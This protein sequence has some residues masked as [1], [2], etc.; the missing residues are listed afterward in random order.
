M[1]KILKPK[2]NVRYSI[3]FLTC[4]AI[5]INYMDRVNFSVATPT[6]MKV[7]NISAVQIGLMGSAFFIPYVLMMLP[8]GY[9]LNKIGP[10]KVL[11]GSLVFWGLATVATA[12]ASSVGTFLAT[13]IFMGLFEAP[14]FPSAS[15]VVAVWFPTEERT[16][17]SGLFDS[18]AR[19]G[20]AFTPP[21]V[22]AMI[23]TWGWQSSFVITG[24]I[25][26][27]FGFVW[28][29]LYHEPDDHPKVS[30]S[31]IAY[32]RKHEIINKEDKVVSKAIPMTRLFAYP[33]LVK[34]GLG[35]AMYLY[36]WNVFT[37]WMPA[38]FVVAKGFSLKS[39]GTAA[40]IPYFCAVVLEIIG[41]V[42]FDKWLRNGAH[43][44]SLR[45]TGMAISLI[46]SAVF[47]Y[48]TIHASTPFWIVF[49]LSA[50][51]GISGFGAGN[52]Q[53]VPQDLA[54][55]GQAGGVSGVYALFGNIGSFFA[56]M[57]T[58]FIIDTRFGYDGAFL[59]AA[60]VALMG[61]AFYIFNSYERIQPKGVDA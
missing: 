8:T 40:M 1:D 33:Q 47:I 3:L 46:G 53:A 20:A 4:L 27:V 28:L 2:T 25:A 37:T 54:P 38:Y 21:L 12:F 36:V 58:G 17:A 49:F 44:S 45:R 39:M 61:A 10:K 18:C 42:M 31:E 52:V 24:V 23:A 13:R 50:F 51:A 15:R 9:M 60:I 14:G 5:V 57:L 26:V 56:P 48:L 41:A 29:A 43:V 55:F 19:I 59:V 34:A 6:I 11:G 30:E 7:F 35:Y 32:I 22:V 16:V